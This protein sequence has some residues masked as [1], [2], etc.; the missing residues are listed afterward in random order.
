MHYGFLGNTDL[1]FSR[2]ILGT[3]QVGK[4]HWV[5]IDDNES[6][7]AIQRAIDVGI[8]AI[9]TASIYGRTNNWRGTQ[10]SSKK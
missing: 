2:I 9:D 1:K 10:K 7:K 4:K 6:L 8:T 3:W 5:G